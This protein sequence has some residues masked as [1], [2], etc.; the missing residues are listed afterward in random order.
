MEIFFVFIS[1]S[2]DL[3]AR[4]HIMANKCR[5]IRQCPYITGI[6]RGISRSQWVSHPLRY[7][8]SSLR[9]ERSNA[10]YHCVPWSSCLSYAVVFGTTACKIGMHIWD[11]VPLRVASLIAG[12]REHSA[13]NS[14]LYSPQYNGLVAKLADFSICCVG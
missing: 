2:E 4:A 9:I 14:F 6:L 8:P 7:T 3:H 1:K 10:S 12:Y 13:Y 11:S 5:I